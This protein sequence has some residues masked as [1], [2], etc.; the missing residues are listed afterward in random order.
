MLLNTL[1]C[2]AQPPAEDFCPRAPCSACGSVSPTARGGRWVLMQS[3]CVSES[4]C[5]SRRFHGPGAL[6]G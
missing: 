2:T 3:S 6:E 4:R 1:G 5:S